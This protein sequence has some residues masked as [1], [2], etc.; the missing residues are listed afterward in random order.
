M[1]FLLIGQRSPRRFPP[2]VRVNGTARRPPPA[3]QGDGSC[4]SCRADAA[5]APVIGA[6]REASTH[7][8]CGRPS[9]FRV[10]KRGAPIARYVRL[11]GRGTLGF[12]LFRFR[13]D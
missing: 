10:R 8:R 2:Q 3:Q 11:G 9:P 1:A 13:R 5:I 12:G 4:A 6:A 7:D